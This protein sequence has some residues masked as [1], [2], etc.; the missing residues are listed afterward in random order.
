MG[1]FNNMLSMSRC[2][3][4][5]GNSC[6]SQ[7]W[8]RRRRRVSCSKPL[9]R[10]CQP[11]LRCSPRRVRHHHR[12][13][14]AGSASPQFLFRGGDKTVRTSPVCLCDNVTIL[15]CTTSRSSCCPT[16]PTSATRTPRC[17]YITAAFRL[18]L[19]ALQQ[20]FMLRRA[21]LVKSSMGA[22]HLR[23]VTHANS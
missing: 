3:P 15:P 1:V 8:P 9:V 10:A 4:S 13:F 2:C 22:N 18:R 6:T 5:Y 19:T 16:A 7:E 17:F 14:V 11:H 12:I 23:Q 21:P 20:V